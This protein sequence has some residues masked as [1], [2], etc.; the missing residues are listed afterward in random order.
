MEKYE[1]SAEEEASQVATNPAHDAADRSISKWVWGG[2]H[3]A[4]G[5]KGGVPFFN[6]GEDIS[7]D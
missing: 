7:S 3:F 6:F 4:S 2:R 5:W 1:L